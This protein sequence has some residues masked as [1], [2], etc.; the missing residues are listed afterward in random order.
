[1]AV[2][3]SVCSWNLLA[4]SLHEAHPGALAWESSR[5]P[6]LRWWLTKLACHDILC[7]QEAERSRVLCELH[8]M[9]A[10]LGFLAVETTRSETLVNVTF[11]MERLTLVWVNPRSRVLLVGLALR[12][13][14]VVGVAN[15]HLESGQGPQQRA[16]SQRQAQM[17]TALSRMRACKP[18]CSIVCGDFNSSLASGSPLREL[19]VQ[20]GL[21]RA[22]LEGPTF[23]VRGCM[24]VIDHNWSDMALR[25]H[26]VLK[27]SNAPSKLELPDAEH[28]S[29]HLPVLATAQVES[30]NQQLMKALEVQP[31]AREASLLNG[32]V[33]HE[34]IQVLRSR[35]PLAGHP[36]SRGKF[37]AREQRLLEAAFLESLRAE[38]AGFLHAWHSWAAEV[39]AIVVTK[40]VTRAA[41]AIH[42]DAQQTAL[43]QKSSEESSRCDARP[44]VE[45]AKSV[46]DPCG[47]AEG[48]KTEA[49][50]I[51]REQYLFGG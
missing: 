37:A 46:W 25:P 15:V 51:G 8:A 36:G 28:P 18:F 49:M 12:D 3:L 41:V 32:A 30:F 4:P 17:S 27:C 5:L 20:S 26:G 21:I 13:G 14:R 22:R 42:V 50:S 1:M 31:Q 39:A 24:H 33:C 10:P 23:M 19:L 48:M 44:T 16:E 45:R 9:L 35:D 40:A 6:A 7:F 34:W 11:K 47:D 2:S 38:D 29:D 43:R